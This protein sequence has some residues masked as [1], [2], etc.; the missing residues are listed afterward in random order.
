MEIPSPEKVIRHRLPPSIAGYVT[1]IINLVSW[2][3]LPTAFISLYSDLRTV[4]SWCGWL[5]R[6]AGQLQPLLL[7]IGHALLEVVRAWRA[8]TAPVL[9][10]LDA[11]FNIHLS[12]PLWDFLVIAIILASR[13]VGHLWHERR[14]TAFKLMYA[15]LVREVAELRKFK[16]AQG[17]ITRKA[18]LGEVNDQREVRARR[19]K[20][21]SLAMRA[22]FVLAGAFG[23]LWMALAIWENYYLN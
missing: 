16:K 12:G 21:R 10:W 18:N 15:D 22:Q 17:N 7:V 6:Q 13:F 14:S 23:V 3:T 2:I 20:R 8:I 4:L 1:S 9:H 5:F 11:T 19:N